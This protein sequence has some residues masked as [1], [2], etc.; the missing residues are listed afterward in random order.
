M[1]IGSG[2]GYY[3]SFGDY[4]SGVISDGSTYIL[5]GNY[6]P[7]GYP[8]GTYFG[9]PWSYSAGYVYISNSGILNGG[10]DPNSPLWYIDQYGNFSGTSNYANNANYANYANYA[11]N[12]D[13]SDGYGGIL[14]SQAWV[15]AQGYSSSGGSSFTN[16]ITTTSTSLTLE[17][18]GDYYGATRL[19]LA[20]RYGLGG[21]KFVNDGL[22][23]VDFS[24]QSSS[25]AYSNIRFENRTGIKLSSNTNGE[26]Q[27]I[28]PN[29]NNYSYFQVG[30]HNTALI[31]GNFLIGTQSDHSNGILQLSG[32]LSF[33]KLGN[34]IN[35]LTGSNSIVGTFSLSSGTKNV[36]NTSVTNNSLIYLTYGLISGTPGILSYTYSSNSFTANSTS[37]SDNSVIN[38]LIIN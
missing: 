12:Q 37:N 21:A 7:W 2:G 36:S 8:V 34:K 6:N 19:I 23:V 1:G 30:Y 15:L 38:Y 24:L 28:S 10:I 3:P 14:A 27:F 33:N 22:D 11:T 13:G 4:G 5:G 16:V 31:S 26:L 20:N 18:T 29:D 35:I 25:G 9:S 32:S 17:Q